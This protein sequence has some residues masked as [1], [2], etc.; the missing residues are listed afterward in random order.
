MQSLNC[1]KILKKSPA[2][3]TELYYTMANISDSVGQ[4]N[5]WVVFRSLKTR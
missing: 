4:T 1:L 2:E 3:V 5:R